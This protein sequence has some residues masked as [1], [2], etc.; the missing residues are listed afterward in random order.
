MEEM[1]SRSS[2]WADLGATAM[3]MELEVHALGGSRSRHLT[4][5]PNLLARTVQG[6]GRGRIGGGGGETRR[7]RGITS[8]R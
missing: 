6:G 8:E 3:E 7:R 2:P 1:S 5:S 4:C